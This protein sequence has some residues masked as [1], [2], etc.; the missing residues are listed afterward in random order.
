MFGKG[1]FFFSVF[2]LLNICNF[3][4]LFLFFWMLEW[5]LFS[6]CAV[7]DVVKV[8]ERDG[9]KMG[10]RAGGT[11]QRHVLG[12][13]LV[14]FDDG[15]KGLDLLFQSYRCFVPPFL[16]FQPGAFSLIFLPL[17]EKHSP[18]LHLPSRTWI[19][20][21]F[22]SFL[23]SLLIMPTCFKTLKFFSQVF[24]DASL[25]NSQLFCLHRFLFFLGEWGGGGRE[26]RTKIPAVWGGLA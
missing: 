2:I 16:L 4:F 9:E 11:L 23:P 1:E 25:Y 3:L 6:F 10:V 21:F 19:I 26:E 24:T 12:N 17:K 20:L 13:T 18:F 22:F 8:E 5:F 15:A 7:C 14:S